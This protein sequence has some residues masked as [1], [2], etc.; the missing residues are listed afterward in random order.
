LVG[1]VEQVGESKK[2]YLSWLNGQFGFGFQAFRVSNDE[3]EVTTR[4]ATDGTWQMAVQSNT[5]DIEDEKR[6][7]DKA[8]PHPTGT[9][10]VLRGFESHW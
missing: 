9:K 1:L 5:N 2:K 6:V 8:F 7:P 10:V 3:A 4:S